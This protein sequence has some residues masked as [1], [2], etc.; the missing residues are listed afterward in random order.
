MSDLFIPAG[1]Y[2]PTLDCRL[3]DASTAVDLTGLTVRFLMWSSD[4][5]LR[6]DQTSTGTAVSVLNSTAGIVRYAW[7]ST[8][9]PPS[10]EVGTYYA[11]WLVPSSQPFWYPSDRPLSII[12]EPAGS[13]T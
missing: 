4:D 7:Q 9:P 10:R 2:G 11:R 5:V 3:E 12:V 8:D 1:S 13:T 6:V